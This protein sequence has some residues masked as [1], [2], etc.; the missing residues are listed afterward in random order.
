[1]QANTLV[2]GEPPAA[3]DPQKAQSIIPQG[4]QANSINETDAL[5]RE[6]ML[7]MRIT[8][9][10]DMLTFNSIKVMNTVI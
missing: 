2:Y 4:M 8:L 3:N 1:M 7:S 10:S 9:G 5:F 6:T